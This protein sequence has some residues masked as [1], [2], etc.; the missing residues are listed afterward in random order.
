MMDFEMDALFLLSIT[1]TRCQG[2]I[3]C[4]FRRRCYDVPRIIA[5]AFGQRRSNS[6]GC[7]F[8]QKQSLCLSLQHDYFDAIFSHHWSLMFG[9]RLCFSV[10]PASSWLPTLPVEYPDTSIHLCAHLPVSSV[11]FNSPRLWDRKYRHEQYISVLWFGSLS[12][13]RIGAVFQAFL[14][15]A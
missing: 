3:K 10:L 13:L 1:H 4:G 2:L 6:K 12:A 5:P 8:G 9:V 11:C 15:T 7:H 14:H